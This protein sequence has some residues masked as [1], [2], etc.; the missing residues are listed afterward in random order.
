MTCSGIPR[1]AVS[2]G[3]RWSEGPGSHAGPTGGVG[4]AVGGR[5]DSEHVRFAKVPSLRSEGKEGE[6]LGEHL[7]IKKSDQRA[8]SQEKRG[9]QES[10]GGLQRGTMSTEGVF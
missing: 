3:R 5:L 9:E 10:G 7:S 8:E 4:A 1:R 6:G 2:R